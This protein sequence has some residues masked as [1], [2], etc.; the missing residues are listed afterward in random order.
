M[1]TFAH[2]HHAGVDELLVEFIHLGEHLG[3]RELTSFRR[4]VG[5]HENQDSH[6]ELLHPQ[7]ALR[8]YGTE[9]K[10]R[11]HSE[12]RTAQQRSAKPAEQQAA[13]MRRRTTWLSRGR[14]QPFPA[15]F[16]LYYA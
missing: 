12:F 14:D 13:V 10:H 9:S 7:S 2:L 3:A 6:T 8:V 4:I 1:Q 11:A 5:F 16:R 15:S